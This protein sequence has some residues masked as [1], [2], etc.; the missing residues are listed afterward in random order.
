MQSDG[1]WSEARGC[2]HERA[3][4]PREFLGGHVNIA[5][6]FDTVCF[7]TRSSFN[8][9]SCAKWL[10]SEQEMVRGDSRGLSDLLPGNWI[11]TLTTLR[12]MAE[13]ENRF[14]DRL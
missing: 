7:A 14:V 8:S 11:L 3:M 10:G 2:C 6:E 5:T 12:N 9:L 1:W 4:K 13:G